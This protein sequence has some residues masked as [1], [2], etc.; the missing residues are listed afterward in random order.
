MNTINKQVGALL[1]LPEGVLETDIDY[2]YVPFLVVKNLTR[3][4]LYVNIMKKTSEYLRTIGDDLPILLNATVNVIPR[5][6]KKTGQR[7]CNS[8]LSENELCYMHQLSDDVTDK[9][10]VGLLLFKGCYVL[11]TKNLGVKYHLANGTRAKV[12]G[13]QFPVGTIYKETKYK[14]ISVIEPYKSGTTAFIRDDLA[15]VDFVLINICKKLICEKPSNQPPNLPVNV[16]AIPVMKV[17]VQKSIK[18]PNG[19]NRSS[20]A[21]S[22]EQ[23]PLRQGNTLTTYSVRNQYCRYNIAETNTRDFYVAFSRGK[24]GMQSISLEKPI[25][26]SF[27]KKCQPNKSLIKEMKCLINFH[28]ETKEMLMF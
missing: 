20:V 1:K 14:G 19:F 2:D 25:T 26:D 4:R 21:I 9:M 18:L 7:D 5:L 12:V 6:N 15:T 22:I 16:V 11:V 23:I 17:N 10:P 24:F 28:N 3:Q 13:W 8:P 27:T